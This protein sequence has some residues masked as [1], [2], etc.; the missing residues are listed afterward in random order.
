MGK[1]KKFKA[2][3][4]VEKEKMNPENDCLN[5]LQYWQK[6]VCIRL[7]ISALNYVK[8]LDSTLKCPSVGV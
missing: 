4:K 8:M 3:K 6:Y 7:F 2:Y 5:L 1:W